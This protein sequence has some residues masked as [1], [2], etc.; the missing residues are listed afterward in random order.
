M[1][2]R[3]GI[4]ARCT[5]GREKIKKSPRGNEARSNHSE[6]GETTSQYLQVRLFMPF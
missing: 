3:K 1:R 4:R 6:T 2:P 5:A